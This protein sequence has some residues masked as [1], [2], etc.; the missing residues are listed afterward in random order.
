MHNEG[1][2]GTIRSSRSRDRTVPIESAH[3]LRAG[4]QRPLAAL[5]RPRSTGS[6]SATRTV[7]GSRDG[8]VYGTSSTISSA[9][10]RRRCW[11][12]PYRYLTAAKRSPNRRVSR[13]VPR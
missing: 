10:F 9:V 6:S 5:T 8:G 11:A 13:S 2:H 12:T 7:T 3:T 4:S 1:D